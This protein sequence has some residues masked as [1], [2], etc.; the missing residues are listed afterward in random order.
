M[1]SERKGS[2]NKLVDVVTQIVKDS[3]KMVI[4]RDEIS[5][6]IQWLIY[7]G[8]IGECALCNNGNINDVIPAR[9]LYYMDCGIASYIASQ[10]ALPES[11]LTGLLTET[12]AFAE[13][14]RLY[15]TG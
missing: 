9:R 14:Y 3:Q 1:C 4:S 2:G 7:S 5:N 15:A 10:V 12:F 6:A 11:N 13:L 8:I